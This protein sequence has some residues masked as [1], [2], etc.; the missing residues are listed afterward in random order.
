MNK[1]TK[2]SPNRFEPYYNLGKLYR[3]QGKYDI[4]ISNFDKAI[5][6]NNGYFKTYYYRGLIEKDVNKKFY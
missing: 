6:K 3:I 5:E 1:A 2:I 4:S